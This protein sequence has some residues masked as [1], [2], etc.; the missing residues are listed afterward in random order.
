MSSPYSR[1]QWRSRVW[2]AEEPPSDEVIEHIERLSR[3]EAEDAMGAGETTVS[4]VPDGFHLVGVKFP[5]EDPNQ[6]NE[7][8]EHELGDLESL[9]NPGGA[10][11]AQEAQLA[12]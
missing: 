5:G 1:Q 12:A 7:I 2:I 8:I 4:Q 9:L 10:T 6:I 11:Q 3:L